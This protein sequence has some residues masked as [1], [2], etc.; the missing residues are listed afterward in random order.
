MEILQNIFDNFIQENFNPKKIFIRIITKKLKESGIILHKKQLHELEKT[1]ENTDNFGN[2]SFQVDEKEALECPSDLKEQ[3]KKSITIDSKDLEDICD[4]IIPNYEELIP[5][6]ASEAA[7]KYQE[8]CEVLGY[9]KLTE[10]EL[11]KIKERY[12]CFVNKYG[13][14]FK[15]DYGWASVAIGKDSPRIA[16]IE[17]VVGLEYMRPYYKMASHN[18][19]ANPKGVFFKL[20]LIPESGDILLTGPSNLGLAD[21][22]HSTAISLLQIT[23][24]L[25]TFK[26]NLDRIVIC[27]ILSSLEK[28]I[29][30]AFLHVE[31][32][33]KENKAT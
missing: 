1:I 21:P 2:F 15:N 9:Q 22:G 32:E 10:E 16:D 30:E 28:E 19:H 3:L 17:A 6:I 12:D 11:S 13:A 23:T 5:K 8:H 20:G 7:I 24:N 29:G 33:L 18:V 26:P 25:L 4:K 27:Y 31:C 14:S